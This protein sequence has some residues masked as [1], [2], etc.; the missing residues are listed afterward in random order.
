MRSKN[1]I[2]SGGLASA[3]LAAVVTI[4]KTAERDKQLLYTH[5][6]AVTYE[7]GITAADHRV[8]D[9][10]QYSLVLIGLVILAAYLAVRDQ[11]LKEPQPDRPSVG[12]SAE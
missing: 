2:V 10:T 3:T 11:T 12:P 8:T 7:T 5:W 6:S 1:G 4:V 9:V